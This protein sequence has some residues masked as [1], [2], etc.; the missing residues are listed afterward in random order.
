MTY[1]N[2]TTSEWFDQQVKHKNYLPNEKVETVDEVEQMIREAVENYDPM[3]HKNLEELEQMEDDF[4]DDKFFMEY[5]QKKLNEIKE[6][7]KGAY[8]IMRE[9][10]YDDYKAEV[11]EASKEVPV[12]ILLHQEYIE[13]SK[14]LNQILMNMA[15]KFPAVK[16]L[17]I[18]ASNCVQNFRDSDV[19]TIFVYR[20]G[21]IY[22]QFLPA[23][24]YFGGNNMNW[25]KVEWIFS[26]IGILKTDL[27]EDPFDDNNVFTVKKLKKKEK[28]DD[29]SDSDD[30]KPSK[31]KVY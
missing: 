3:E 23:T 10:R 24:Y 19:P 27:E 9:I 8:G 5:K 26:S 30:D 13:T 1:V 6:K 31:Y 17:R 4:E 20:D 15:K 16:F 29:E 14:V 25:K 18:Q 12:V 11:T 21:K 2:G 7:S 28:R 22:Q